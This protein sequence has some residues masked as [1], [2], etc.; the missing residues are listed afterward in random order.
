MM[1][2]T[3]IR[4]PQEFGSFQVLEAKLFFPANILACLNRGLKCVAFWL[5]VPANPFTTTSVVMLKE[6]VTIS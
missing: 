6:S 4:G 1:I 5:L 3:R 2:S